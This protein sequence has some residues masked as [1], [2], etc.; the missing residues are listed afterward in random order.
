MELSLQPEPLA[1]CRLEEASPIPVWALEAVPLHVS[2]TAGELSVVCPAVRVPDGVRVEGPWQAIA[3]QGPLDFALTG[4][5]ASLAGPLAEAGISLFAISTFDTD[6]I[7]VRAA[8][9]ARAQAVLA[10][11]GHTFLP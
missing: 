3:V 11:A 9:V 7:L 1:I 4:V 6:Y 5:L 8:D 10:A 2:R